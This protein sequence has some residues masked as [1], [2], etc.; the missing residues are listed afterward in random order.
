L[1]LSRNREPFD[2]CHRCPGSQTGTSARP[3]INSISVSRR[4]A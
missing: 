3:H 4:R 2:G 1:P